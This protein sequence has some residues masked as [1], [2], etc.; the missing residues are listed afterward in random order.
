MVNDYFHYL[1]GL[2]AGLIFLVIGVKMLA[3]LIWEKC[4]RDGP[5]GFWKNFGIGL[6]LVI[7]SFAM[8]VGLTVLK[9]VW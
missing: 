3:E 5:L 2:V 6:E 9:A 4:H 1:W 8:A 7:I